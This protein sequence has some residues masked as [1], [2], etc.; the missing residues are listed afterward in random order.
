M[1]LPRIGQPSWSSTRLQTGATRIRK[2]E[3]SIR[4]A[5]RGTPRS[6][7]THHC[8][9]GDFVGLTAVPDP[10]WLPVAAGDFDGDGKADVLWRSLGNANGPGTGENTIWKS[11]NGATQQA[12]HTVGDYEW[13]VMPTEGTIGIFF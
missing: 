9:P 5:G 13:Q 8:R 12:V 1:R 2:P 6:S 3:L 11:G 7:K 4:P 10:A